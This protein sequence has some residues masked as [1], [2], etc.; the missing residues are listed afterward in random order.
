ML[1]SVNSL[2][3]NCVQSLGISN[4]VAKVW[5]IVFAGVVGS[6]ALPLAGILLKRE[7]HLYQRCNSSIKGTSAD[8]VLGDLKV[9]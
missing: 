2:A 4:V 1:V 7:E 5:V 8:A 3:D 9:R 6:L